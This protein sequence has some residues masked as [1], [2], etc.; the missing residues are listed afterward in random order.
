MIDKTQE[1]TIVTFVLDRSGSMSACK[2]ATIE[3]FNAYV[4]GLKA[5][6]DGICFSL[7]QFDT[8][9]IETTWKNAPIAVV[10]GL[11]HDTYQPRGGTPLIDAAYK[12]IKAVEKK[13][14]DY[15]AAPK[16]VICIQTDGEENSSREHTWEALTTL[17]KEKMALGWQFNF[18]GAGIDAYLQSQRMGLSAEHTM[19]YDHNDRDA[20]RAAF[21][22]SAENAQSFRRGRAKST[23]YSAMQKLAAKD[24]FDRSQAPPPSHDVEL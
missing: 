17:I 24:R 7:I 8:V 6:A 2:D 11:T 19:S 21:A 13:V 9:G 16:I 1:Q 22:A 3:A 10:A 20:T 12:T 14:A 18:M 15:S 5:D 23:G 4:A